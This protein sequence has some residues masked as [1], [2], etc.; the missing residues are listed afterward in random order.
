MEDNNES[1]DDSEESKYWEDSED[2]EFLS[3]EQDEEDED[4]SEVEDEEDEEDSE[5]D[6]EDS[7]ED[8]NGD[9]PF[10]ILAE[11]PSVCRRGEQISGGCETP[12]VVP[13]STSLFSQMTDVAIAESYGTDGESAELESPVPPLRRTN[14]LANRNTGTGVTWTT[15]VR[16]IR[17][18]PVLAL[19]QH[20]PRCFTIQ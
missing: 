16:R 17:L 12:D 6:E 13:T 3:E 2:G 15:T 7:E 20:S 11:G 18:G 10:Y 8:F 4:D 9:P 19:L 1:H 5:E 14:R